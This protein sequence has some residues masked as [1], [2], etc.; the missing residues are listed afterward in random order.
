MEFTESYRPFFQA[1][2]HN[3]GNQAYHYL[4]G[5]LGHSRLK[6]M[7]RMCEYV[8]GGDYQSQQQF[9]SDSPWDHRALLNRVA[10]DASALLG[11]PQSVLAIDES[12]QR[13][14]GKMSVGVARQWSGREGKVDNCQVGVYGALCRG[15]RVALV[16]A[17]LYLPQCWSV[18]EQRCQ[19]AKIPEPERVFRTKTQIAWEIIEN[20]C[21][22]RL[23]FGWIA[24]DALY[25]RDTAL[26][27]RCDDRGLSFV[28]DVPCSMQVF[29]R[30]PRLEDTRPVRLDSLFARMH[31][32]LWRGVDVREGTKGTVRRNRVCCV[33]VWV[34]CADDTVR[35]WRVLCLFD[36]LT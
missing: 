3:V 5:L 9:L 16:D 23:R 32:R 24:W 36:A 2:R 18:D 29:E 30:D 4:S 15:E 17:R 35:Q 8:A 7:E 14:K 21:A 25:G 20:A 1:Y 11:G 6:N 26:L 28:A 27:S 22:Q 31:P 13:K 34:K 12:A 33:I 19:K 10:R